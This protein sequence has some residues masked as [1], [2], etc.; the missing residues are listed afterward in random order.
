MNRI[1]SEKP[2][3][4]AIVLQIVALEQAVHYWRDS[5]QYAEGQRYRDEMARANELGN[6][7]RQL[8]NQLEAQS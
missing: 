1:D 8:R 4:A 5:A 6:Q 7:I 3:R 2:D